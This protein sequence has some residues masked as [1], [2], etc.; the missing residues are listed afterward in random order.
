MA[1][2]RTAPEESDAA[3]IGG[4]YTLDFFFAERHTTESNFHIETTIACFEVIPG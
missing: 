3:A 1:A 2:A 4:E